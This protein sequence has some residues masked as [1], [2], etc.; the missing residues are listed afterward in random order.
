MLKIDHIYCGDSSKILPEFDDSCVDLT[1]TSPPYDDLRKYGKTNSDW[2]CDVF[3]S[4]AR[5]LYRVTKDGGVV[6]WIVNDK[7]TNGSKTCTSFKQLMYFNEIGFNVN[8]VMIWEKTNAMPT[9]RQP[10]Y[11]DVFEYMFIFSKGKPKTF[12]PIMIP[13]KSAGTKYNSTAKNIGGECGRRK[14]NYTVN[15]E[16]V[17]GNIWQCAVAQNKTSHPAVYPEKLIIDHILSWT[18]ENDIV[19]DPFIGSG[20]TALAAIKTN[21]HYIGIDTNQNYCDLAN[22]RIN[23]LNASIQPKGSHN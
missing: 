23:I 14:L 8:D 17:K 13:C 3:E 12:N 9:V 4:I 6:V 7:T 16:K 5:Q 15:R 19:L 1:V 20:T 2:N 11:S 22:E 10:R 21:R 18:N